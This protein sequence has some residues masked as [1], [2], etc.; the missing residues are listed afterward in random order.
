M[1]EVTEGRSGPAGRK[2]FHVSMPGVTEITFLLRP[3]VSSSAGFRH[4]MLAHE[5][6]VHGRPRAREGEAG[7]GGRIVPGG[8]RPPPKPPG[9]ALQ[10]QAA[11]DIEQSVKRAFPSPI[12]QTGADR[13]E[14]DNCAPQLKAMREG[15]IALHALSKGHYPGKRMNSNILPGLLNV[16]F[17]SC[18]RAQD[19]GLNPHRN[20]GIEI[21]FLETGGVG[22]EV[23]GR[24]H[25]LRAGH[26][27][28][29]RPW[30]LHKLGDPHIGRGCL[31]WLILDVGARRPNQEWKWPSWLVLD[32]H[33]LAELTGKLRHCEQSVWMTGPRVGQVFHELADCVLRWNGPR[34]ASRLAVA[35]NRVLV[36]LLETLDEHHDEELPAVDSR[37]R[38][39]ELFLRDLADNPASSAEPWSLATMSRQCGM[40]ITALA[41]H[42]RELV[43]NGPMAY[44]NLC[45][46]E[47]AAKALRARPGDPV[48]AIAM[49]AGFNSSQYFATAFRKRY[50]TTPLAYRSAALADDGKTDITRRDASTARGRRGRAC[51]SPRH[52]R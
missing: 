30:Q 16:G 34:M 20:E 40:G 17:W 45:R 29:T 10:D 31:Y 13:F 25:A 37:K 42:C 1:V 5:T 33:D 11:N 46:L 35:V 4:V 19:W 41:K 43:N 8:W 52:R 23:D 49:E 26:L 39:V 47:H 50:R 22:F 14:I 3:I 21:V 7:L 9:R 48:T 36:E 18:R 12:Y 51:D 24:T 28:L 38:T 2:R 27:T 15:K 44:L 6:R 32:P